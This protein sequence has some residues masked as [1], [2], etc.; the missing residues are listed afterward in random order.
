MGANWIRLGLLDNKRM[1]EKMLD[2]VI[3][4]SKLYLAKT[5]WSIV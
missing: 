1:P 2:S 5:R 4:V 3:K